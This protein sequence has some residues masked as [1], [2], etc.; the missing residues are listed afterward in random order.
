MFVLVQKLL[1]KHLLSRLARHL[2]A[3]EIVVIKTL[4]INLF[5][6]FYRVDI[7]EARRTNK[8]DYLNFNDFFTRSLKEGARPIHGRISS[9]ADGTVL[10]CGN[11]IDNTLLQSKKHNYT[12]QNLLADETNEFNG[13]SYITIYLAPHNYHRVHA[14]RTAELHQT[15]YVPGELFSVN[16]NTSKILPD[17]LARN[18]RLVC[19]FRTDDGPMALILVG[20]MLVA[21]IKPIWLTTAY[22]PRLEV[23]TEMQ[24]SFKQGD[25][26]AHFEMGSTVILLLR[27]PLNFVVKQG[28]QIKFGQAIIR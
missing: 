3:C 27:E 28:D 2:A 19:R 13:G 5:C 20:A 26:I 22:K 24:Y 6:L 14:P 16:P 11:I 7:K 15:S 12:V 1:P 9:P 25:E 17:L 23:A 10:A 8:A 18:E 21:G 4:F